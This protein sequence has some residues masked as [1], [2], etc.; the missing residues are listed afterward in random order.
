MRN[1]ALVGRI[2]RATLRRKWMSLAAFAFG[3]AFFHAQVALSYPAIG[4][5]ATVQSVVNTF[6]DGLRTLLRIAPN[7]QAAFGLQDY[8]AFSWFHPVFLGLGAAF[9]VS[10]ATDALA[11]EIDRGSIYLILSRP[12]PRWTLVAGKCLEMVLGAAC[13]VAAG[14]VGMAVGVA[15][16]V[17]EPLPLARYLLVAPMAWGLFAALGAGALVISSV[18][19]RTALAGGL[20]SAWTLVAFVLD[21]IPAVAESPLAWLNP[22][23]YYFPQEIVAT[24]QMDWLGL[25]AL[26]LWTLAAT[27]VAAWLFS[28]RDLA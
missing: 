13:L 28:R 4:G 7:L 16:A 26:L 6:P 23:H 2:W 20:T 24:G 3:M 19:S 14:W 21:V 8:L 15:A 1:L 17:D 22:W 10:R 12:L 11:G 18:T 25:A 5:I 27:G 9:V